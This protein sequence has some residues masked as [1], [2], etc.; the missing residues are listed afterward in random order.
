LGVLE[1]SLR[2]AEHVSSSPLR[3]TDP[4]GQTITLPAG[5]AHGDEIILRYRGRAVLLKVRVRER[6]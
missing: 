5:T 6:S 4:G 3:L 2:E 1:L